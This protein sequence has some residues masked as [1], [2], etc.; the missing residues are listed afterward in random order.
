MPNLNI[1]FNRN[2]T[3][4]YDLDTFERYK[5]EGIEVDSSYGYHFHNGFICGICQ[6]FPMFNYQRRTELGIMQLPIIIKENGS[7]YIDKSPQ[8]MYDDII[9]I[10][11][12]TISYNGDFTLL[13]H[14][15][16]MNTF[17]G[18]ACKRV[19]RKVIEFINIKVK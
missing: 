19:Y 15:N 6:M 17:E 1:S 16:K 7:F 4:Q 13:W 2:H 14:T 18:I 11:N 5:Q 3:L 10:F 8:T 12:K 9:S